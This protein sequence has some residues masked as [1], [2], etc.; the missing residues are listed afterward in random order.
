MLTTSSL[1]RVAAEA[2]P[3]DRVALERYRPNIVIETPGLTAFAENDWRGKRLRIGDT[4]ELALD[5]PTPRCAIPMLAY[6]DEPA[7]MG[8]VV[9]VNRLNRIPIP[10][11]GEGLFP[12]SASLRLSRRS[13]R[14][15]AATLSAWGIE[16]RSRPIGR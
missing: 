5:I 11:L 2:A 14:C 16:P 15:V 9:A 6:A 3:A 12:V 13:A 4:L 8:A 10:E 7:A 1:A